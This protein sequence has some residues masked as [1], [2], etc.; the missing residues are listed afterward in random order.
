MTRT[1]VQNDRI[2][3]HAERVLTAPEV[4][5]DREGTDPERGSRESYE[6]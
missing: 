6:R 5:V 3:E 4:I 1:V 2:V